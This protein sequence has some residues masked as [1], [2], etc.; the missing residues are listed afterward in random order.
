MHASHYYFYYSDHTKYD[1]YSLAFKFNV[2]NL[3]YTRFKKNYE[4]YTSTV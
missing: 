1:I 4:P 3:Y 2:F